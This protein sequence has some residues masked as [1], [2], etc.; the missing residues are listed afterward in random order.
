MS[1]YLGSDQAAGACAPAQAITSLVPSRENFRLI[2]LRA[3]ESGSI[4]LSG[5]FKK[6]CRSRGF[7]TLDAA[8]VID[9][10]VIVVGPTYDALRHS[11]KCE[12]MGTVEGRLWTLVVALY[13]DSDFEA[14]PQGVYVTAHRIDKRRA[15]RKKAK[16]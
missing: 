6:R 8:E 12:F 1:D 10:G 7:S 16:G 15:L 9:S 13:C 14:A 11:I 5:H 2:V 3:K 4:Q